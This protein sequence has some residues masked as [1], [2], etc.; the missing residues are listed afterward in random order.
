MVQ[1]QWL[2]V[3][4]PESA[5]QFIPYRTMTL[6]N[7]TLNE[8]QLTVCTKGSVKFTVMNI[9]ILYIYMYYACK[10]VYD[11]CVCLNNGCT[12]VH[13]GSVHVFVHVLR[14]VVHLFLRFLT[15]LN[16]TDYFNCYIIM[17]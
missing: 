8:L 11:A 4:T 12:H 13:D 1:R 17:V 3:V 9:I 7:G 2:S 5:S 10:Y 15:T 6:I 14:L 16:I